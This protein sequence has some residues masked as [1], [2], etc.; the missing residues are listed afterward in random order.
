MKLSFLVGITA[1]KMYFGRISMGLESSEHDE[2]EKIPV[3][4]S[5]LGIFVAA[6]SYKHYRPVP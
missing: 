3:F 2:H 5:D 1:V 4:C 6:V